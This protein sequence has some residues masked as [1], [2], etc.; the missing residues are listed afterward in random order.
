MH[1]HRIA[2]ATLGGIALLAGIG[3][4]AQAKSE[5]PVGVETSIPFASSSGIRNFRA[6]GNSALWIEG[7]RGQWYR[8]ELMGYCQGLNFAWNIGFDTRGSMSLD[9]FGRIVVEG[10]HCPISSLKT[11]AAPPKKA[12]KAKADA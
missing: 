1:K 9:R 7:Q 6:D 10:R 12:K 5:R 8:A 3:G 4:A 11:A 2:V